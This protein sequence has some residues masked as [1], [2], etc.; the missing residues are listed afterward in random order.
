MTASNAHHHTNFDTAAVTAQDEESKQ[1]QEEGYSSDEDFLES[2]LDGV[3]PYDVVCGRQKEAFRNVGNRRFRVTVS[4]FMEKYVAASTRQCKSKVIAAVAEQVKANSGRFLKRRNNEWVE[5]DDKQAKEKV[6]HAL[7][8][9]VSARE[10]VVSRKA[11]KRT[12]AE[13]GFVR[14]PNFFRPLTIRATTADDSTACSSSESRSLDVTSHST[15]IVIEDGSP[16]EGSFIDSETVLAG[17]RRLRHDDATDS[18]H[19]DWEALLK[20]CEEEDEHEV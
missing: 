5:L 13:V 7:R 17:M 10:S 14:N 3:G 12:C 16:H 4:L 15:D 8:D 18:G 2:C 11:L 19:I 1:S 9:M 6:G 20:E